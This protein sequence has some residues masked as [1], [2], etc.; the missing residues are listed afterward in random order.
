MAEVDGR[1]IRELGDSECGLVLVYRTRL[2]VREDD[3]MER[4]YKREFATL[5]DCMHTRAAM[6][7]W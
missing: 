3:L 5:Y 1:G 2:V 7:G 6:S 4:V